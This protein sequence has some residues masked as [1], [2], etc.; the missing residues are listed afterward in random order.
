MTTIQLLKNRCSFDSTNRAFIY[1]HRFDFFSNILNVNQRRTIFKHIISIRIIISFIFTFLKN[2]KYLEICVKILKFLISKPFKKTIHQNFEK[3]HNEQKTF[4]LLLTKIVR[5]EKIEIF[6]ESIYWKVYRQLWLYVMRHFSEMIDHSS[7]TKNAK[8]KMKLLDF[9]Y[10]WWYEITKLAKCCEYQRFQVSYSIEIDA[11]EQMTKNFLFRIRPSSLYTFKN[12]NLNQTLGQIM[13]I[14]E[15]IYLSQFTND[16]DHELISC[17]T[18]ISHR[19]NVSFW[20]SFYFDRSNLFL[21][22]IY[23]FYSGNRTATT[24]FVKSA[25][26]KIFLDINFLMKLRCL[27]LG[28][29]RSQISY[30]LTPFKVRRVRKLLTSV[31]YRNKHLQ[32]MIPPCS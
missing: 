10:S 25:M 5:D 7:R 30:L 28:M 17:E 32:A 21:T 31:G 19:C 22:Q 20:S 29:N 13:T 16:N 14:L 6:A 11:D 1:S 27:I 23:R 18:D 2:T 26:F 15:K 8:F 12:S 9:E 4:T 24:L 3:L